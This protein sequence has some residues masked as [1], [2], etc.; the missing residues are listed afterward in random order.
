MA[1]YTASPSLKHQRSVPDLRRTQDNVSDLNISVSFL[2]A[3]G[4]AQQRVRHLKSDSILRSALEDPRSADNNGLQATEWKDFALVSSPKEND[5]T[6]ISRS[7]SSAAI[8][9][10]A[11]SGSKRSLPG[12]GSVKKPEERV[13]SHRLTRP[14]DGGTIY[15]R[16]SESI[17]DL[18]NATRHST[19]SSRDL[20]FDA[21]VAPIEVPKASDQAP[22]ELHKS[23]FRS[24]VK[25]FL[26]LGVTFQVSIILLTISIVLGVQDSNGS[27]INTGAVICGVC[28]A[29]ILLCTLLSAYD[30][31]KIPRDREVKSKVCKD[32]EPREIMHKKVGK[33]DKSKIRVLN[34]YQLNT[35]G[36]WEQAEASPF[37]DSSEGGRASVFDVER[38]LPIEKQSI[39]LTAFRTTKSQIKVLERYALAENGEWYKVAVAPRSSAHDV[40]SSSQHGPEVYNTGVNSFNP[41]NRFHAVGENGQAHAQQPDDDD[42]HHLHYPSRNGNRD[43]SAARDLPALITKFGAHPGLSGLTYKPASRITTIERAMMSGALDEWG[44]VQEQHSIENPCSAQTSLQEVEEEDND[45]ATSRIIS[46]YS[47]QSSNEDPHHK[48][49]RNMESTTSLNVS[50]IEVPAALHFRPGR[51]SNR[52]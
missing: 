13:V 30:L 35:G 19:V 16:V 15:P 46:L 20:H 44:K 48:V 47:S 28:G 25:V 32:G 11:V 51:F 34:S 41:H 52:T 33:I 50:P 5:G 29:A 6:E 3:E 26:V 12:Q 17:L 21:S 23:F 22:P 38:G 9:K 14:F 2:A 18:K 36:V 45:D 10:E 4:E 31:L 40:Q 37:R 8:Q 42:N 27:G 7:Y 49:I 24:R 43:R 1:S 39:D